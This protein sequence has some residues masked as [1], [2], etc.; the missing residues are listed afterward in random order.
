LEEQRAL[1]EKFALQGI[2]FVN[3]PQ[4]GMTFQ[5]G[6]LPYAVLIGTDTILVAQGL[7]NSREHLESLVHAAETGMPSIQTY[8]AAS[9]R[10]V[11]EAA[12]QH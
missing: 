1:I 3:S 10:P 7:V 2:D 12:H 9:K 5:V 4:I 11:E 8:L 6:K